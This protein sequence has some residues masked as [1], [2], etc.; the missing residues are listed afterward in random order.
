L[1]NIACDRA[2]L[3]AFTLGQHR[4]TNSVVKRAIRELDGKKIRPRHPRVYREKLI[5]TLLVVLVVL[6]A[7][8][9]IGLTVLNRHGW[10]FGERALPLNVEQSP[11]PPTVLLEEEEP[12]A[13][14]AESPPPPQPP[15][16]EPSTEE[17]AAPTAQAATV[18]TVQP[19]PVQDLE[20]MIVSTNTLESRIGALKAVLTQWNSTHPLDIESVDGVDDD[21]FFRIAVRQRAMEVLRVQGN[22]NLIRKLNLPAILEFSNLAGNRSL[23]LAIVGIE[24]NILRLSDG[25]QTHSI[26][27]ASLAGRWN[28]VAYIPWKNYYNYVGIIPISSPGEVIISLKVHLKILGFPIESMTAAYDIA[29][30][31]AIETIQARYGLDVD[32][33]VGPL[34]KIVLYNEDNS[35]NV[36]RLAGLPSE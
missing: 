24:D 1:I 7:G 8:L 20:Q 16:A 35:L 11:S 26:A 14:V 34:T 17:D 13:E 31:S 32:G 25:D 19:P 4:I 6:V 2:L 5:I 30:R 18:E 27:Q 36:P 10:V 23:F 22:L 28:G 15:V 3:T 21:T 9:I 12:I 33:M 29:T